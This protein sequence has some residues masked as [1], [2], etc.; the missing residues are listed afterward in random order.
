MKRFIS[1]LLI[2]C[3]LITVSS[4]VT[5]RKEAT[6]P[7]QTL[8]NTQDNLDQIPSEKS[9]GMSL[10]YT[11][12]PAS[13][14]WLE[15]VANTD[16]ASLK[17]ECDLADNVVLGS[18]TVTDSIA[19]MGQILSGSTKQKLQPN[20]IIEKGG[21][22][23]KDI[24]DTAV[25]KNGQTI[26][27]GS[28]VVDELSGT[29]FKV[30]SPTI[31]SGIFDADSELSEMV[32]PLENTYSLIKPELHEVIKDFNM[33]EQTVTLNKAN[34]VG[35]APNIENSIKPFFKA[36]PM[37]VGDEDKTFKTLTG[38]NLIELQFKDTAL[39]GLVGNSTINVKLSGGIAVDGVDLTGRYSANG[40]YEIS[41][42]L[43]QECY[44]VVELDAEIHEEIKVPILGIS[45]PF[46]IGEV[47]GG[48]FAII[49]MNGEFRLGIEA[50][51]TSAC[52]MGIEGG[53]FLYVP[54]SFHPIFKPETPKI[55]GDC[56]MRGKING[57]V[58][59][60]PMLGIEIFGFDLVGAGVLLGAGVNVQS[61]GSMLDIE[62]YASI[63]VYIV[64]LDEYFSLVRERPTIYRKQQ[65]DMEGFKV[66]FLETYVDP[67][68]VGGLIEME[69]K[70]SGGAYIPSENLEYKI[71]IVPECEVDTFDGANREAT[72]SA[73]KANTKKETKDKVRTYPDNK[74]DKTNAEGEFYQKNDEIC[75]GGDQVYLEFISKGKTFF[76]GP[77]TPVLP[78]T[79]ITI[80]YADYF[81]DFVT[82]K[83]E[84]K[85]LIKWESNRL[86]PTQEQQ[87]LVYYEDIIDISPFNDYGMDRDQIPTA[88]QSRHS[89]HRPYVI[90]GTVRIE[91][92]ELGEFDTRKPYYVNGVL[93][94]SAII[95][96]LSEDTTN[97]GISD[98]PPSKI[99]VLAS[100]VV[101]DIVKDITAYNITPAAPEF[102]F[103]RTLDFVEGS[104]KLINEGDKIVNQ[105]AYDEYFWIANPVGTRTITAEMFEYNAKGF[106]T[107]DF[108]GYYENPVTQ[109]RETP[110]TLIPVLDKGKPTG[111]ALFAQRVTVEW[112]WQAHP[113]PIE[114]TSADS[115]QSTASEESSFQVTADGFFPRF[116]LEGEPKR[117]WIDENTGLLYIPQTLNPGVYTFTIH[118]KEGNIIAM[119]GGPDPKS[120]NDSSEPD[121]Q[122]FTLTVVEKSAEPSPTLAPEPSPTTMPDPNVPTVPTPTPTPLP[123]QTPTLTPTYLPTVTPAPT[124]IP[125][126]T[127]SPTPTPA[128]TPTPS[129]TP[130]PEV[131]TAPVLGA[132]RDNYKFK[133]SSANTDFS[134][135]LSATGSAP[136]TYSL[137]P[138]SSRMTV[139][140]EIS[141]DATTGLLRVK[142]GLIGGI[143]ADNYSFILR[144][145]NDVGS[146]TQECTL[147]VT[148]ST[149]PPIKRIKS[150]ESV[151]A[152]PLDFTTLTNSAKI[153]TPQSP[154]A[155]TQLYDLFKNEP[156]A[157][158]LTIRCD[159]PKDVYTYDR[160][161]Y[162]GT[163]FIC[164]DISAKVSL[165]DVMVED[166]AD[167]DVY[168]DYTFYNV[169]TWGDEV[170][171]KDN[172]PVCDQYHYYD[173][174]SL[175]QTLQLTEEQLEEIRAKM[176][177]LIEEEIAEYKNGYKTVN[178]DFS[179]G[180]LRD[181]YFDFSTNPMDITTSSLEFGSLIKEMNLQK[182]GEFNVWLNLETGTVITGRYF[183]CLM[184]NPQAS[185]SFKQDVGDITFA[186]KDI[187]TA[188]D[189]D[190]LNIGFTYAPHETAMLGG[191]G[192]DFKSF[193]Y[194]F[195]HHG[196]LPGM[197]TFAITTTLTE[198]EK[199][200]VYKF[201]AA[202]ND[203]TQI[204]GN[205]TVGEKGV[206]TYKNNT[207]SEYLITTK[208]LTDAFVSEVVALQGSV[209]G[210][211]WWMACIGLFVIL[212]G[213]TIYIFLRKRNRQVAK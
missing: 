202:S 130:T 172:S 121:K 55:T 69:P 7:I 154:T 111:T 188:K 144:V 27:S 170:E 176:Q 51:E 6:I 141:V 48:I 95:D 3:V 13:S 30:V 137:E 100:L 68:R 46:G 191:I 37:S 29:A 25:A 190:L 54:T 163:N 90:N 114:I 21:Y 152:I 129:P 15:L 2:F 60:G 207:M 24:L 123:T 40:G 74:F 42:T 168:S 117:V 205:I 211:N 203:F 128:P 43:Q 174:N 82:G 18:E 195:Q 92:N 136:M 119:L 8:K 41:M 44:V 45:I 149:L 133:M 185:I 50:R 173:P 78:F 71:W 171:I 36:S 199:V 34:I 210:S 83:V 47:Y 127:P 183:T 20:S 17:V 184:S 91:T 87:E 138:Y 89:Q 84:P 76:V 182:G 139:P 143:K 166:P 189:N 204:A 115:T 164:W 88:S 103:T 101:N 1:I 151:Q 32:K 97:N 142:G 104:N 4:P 62:L 165:I 57:Y 19:D 109:T 63:D 118:A 105:V 65:P 98:I 213:A 66:S 146:D 99:G 209:K 102:L 177:K 194:G 181:R 148:A 58:K 31:Y 77:S 53:T 112:V 5:P 64:L 12:L 206:V 153:N 9:T 52:T 61:D 161:V 56:S 197:A 85:R 93:Q 200:N 75:Y 94:P 110:I 80:T 22:I 26:K 208:T 14:K 122:T 23:S 113:N 67:G 157:N 159:D 179:A 196:A 180:G 167:A 187:T 59:F 192:S 81:N 178:Q 162:N 38:D 135:Q 140:S 35:F 212:F 198:G 155:I 156:P 70:Q 160:N 126:P 120:G 147:T 158:K 132:R 16:P 72:L 134:M 201:D 145:S 186:G 49:G 106:S 116:R 86:D 108:K 33:T 169:L 124:P 28:I 10:D 96:V 79:D 193:T 125:T 131:R 39:Q 73:D 11:F 150:M 175:F 107:Q